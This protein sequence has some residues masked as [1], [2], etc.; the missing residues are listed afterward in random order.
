MASARKK[1]KV[2]CDPAKLLQTD[3]VKNAL[4]GAKSLFPKTEKP[5]ER[6]KDMEEFLE[7]VW[8]RIRLATFT[9]TEEFGK[10]FHEDLVPGIV[11]DFGGDP[12]GHMMIGLA[13]AGGAEHFMRWVVMK[14]TTSKR[15]GAAAAAQVTARYKVYHRHQTRHHDSPNHNLAFEGQGAARL[16]AGMSLPEPTGHTPVRPQLG[17]HRHEWKITSS[18]SLPPAMPSQRMPCLNESDADNAGMSLPLTHWSYPRPP[19]TRTAPAMPSQRMPCS[20]E[21]DADNAA[22]IIQQRWKAA[23]IIQRWWL[24]QPSN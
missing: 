17:P 12:T 3:E 22:W 24:M 13:F 11:S 9:N 15:P 2:A 4:G 1:R 19:T 6:N 5:T 20:N 14:F 21:P 18:W 8:D 16:A 7:P 23:W 10:W